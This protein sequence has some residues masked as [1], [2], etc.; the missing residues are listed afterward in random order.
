[1][2]E[3]RGKGGM[4]RGVPS[5]EK[6]RWELYLTNSV[7]PISVKK[8]SGLDTIWKDEGGLKESIRGLTS[9]AKNQ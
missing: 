7:A 6:H 1:M 2:S 4:A 5:I 8:Y 9:Q 3:K